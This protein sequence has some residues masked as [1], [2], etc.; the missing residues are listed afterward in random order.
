MEMKFKIRS[1]KQFA[2]KLSARIQKSGKLGF[3][4]K[5]SE[6]M[7]LKD[8][9]YISFLSTDDSIAATHLVVKREKDEDSFAL[10]KGNT[11]YPFVDAK[12]LFDF[13]G[14]DY[15]SKSYYFEL[16]RE[17]SLDAEL[18]GEVYRV[19]VRINEKSNANEE[20]Q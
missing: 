6:L 11:K 14:I 20:E 18:G 13:F 19:F 17:D 8:G 10:K 5:E 2:T 12:Q 3:G 7:N 4:E 16:T 1:A 9:V 15:A